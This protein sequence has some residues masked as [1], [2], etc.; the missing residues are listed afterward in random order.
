MFTV[1][2]HRGQKI[3]QVPIMGYINSVAYIQ[4][5]ID[6]ILCEV[7]NWA[8][9]YVDDIICDAKSLDNLL[10]K[11]RI[12]FEI[13]MAYRILIK[14]TKSFLNYPDV[15]LLGQ[16]VDSLGL[17]TAT[18]KLQTSKLLTYP[19]TLEALEYYLGLTGYLRSYIHFYTQLSELLHSLKIRLLNSA[20]ISG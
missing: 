15:S 7:R 1:V 5:E 12:L 9:V 17:T 8:C 20:P 2:T 13:F 6:N 19:E 10:S 16:R 3:F 14:P 11:L 18:E 4:R